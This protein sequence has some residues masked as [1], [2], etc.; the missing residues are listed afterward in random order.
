MVKFVQYYNNYNK[1]LQNQD[2]EVVSRS[3]ISSDQM[4]DCW[5]TSAVTTISLESDVSSL[6]L[7]SG[8]LEVDV[9]SVLSPVLTGLN[10][11]SRTDTFSGQF[12]GLQKMDKSSALTHTLKQLQLKSDLDWAG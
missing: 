12:T 6:D 7:V 9:L 11:Q 8:R 3:V 1:Y 2:I 10:T 4:V 5:W